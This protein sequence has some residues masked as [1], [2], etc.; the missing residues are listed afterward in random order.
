MPDF[1]LF[2]LQSRILRQE[3]L[4]CSVCRRVAVGKS[5]LQTGARLGDV[6]HGECH[7]GGEGSRHRFT[8][9]GLGSVRGCWQCRLFCRKQKLLLSAWKPLR[10]R[11]LLRLTHQELEG[12]EGK[13]SICVVLSVFF[14]GL[15][16]RL[17]SHKEGT[18]DWVQELL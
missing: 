4:V 3:L 16:H 1:E 14:S 2:L 11:V 9:L 15:N 13:V 10:E 8:L 18:S 6:S 5:Y 7:F 12:L 17:K